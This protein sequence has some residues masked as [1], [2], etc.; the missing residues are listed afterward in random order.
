MVNNIRDRY[1]FK[2]KDDL[3]PSIF[4]YILAIVSL[5]PG[6]FIGPRI[7]LLWYAYIIILLIF[8]K[9][10]SIIKL[11]II[12]AFIFGGAYQ[13][14]LIGD[15]SRALIVRGINFLLYISIVLLYLKYPKNKNIL[16][17]KYFKYLY[18]LF[19]IIFLSGLINLIDPAN[20][21]QYLWSN[22][23]WVIFALVINTIPLTEKEHKSFVSLIIGII[24]VNSIFGFIQ[25]L[26]LPAQ[27]TPDGYTPDYADLASGML[28]VT[29]GPH[30]TS[31]CLAIG[32]YF[33]YR[34]LILGDKKSIF[35]IILLFLQP[36]ISESKAILVFSM[37]TI[38]L[39]LILITYYLKIFKLSINKIFYG[40]IILLIIYTGI[41]FYSISKQ[42]YYKGYSLESALEHYF[43]S[44]SSI[45]DFSKVQGY[46]DA[47]KN[48]APR[49]KFGIFFGI[50]PS[51]FSNQI[52]GKYY[53]W[54]YYLGY[55]ITERTRFTSADFRI[56]EMTQFISEVGIF[57]FFIFIITIYKL[58][59]LLIKN[60]KSSPDNG[61]KIFLIFVSQ[62]LIIIVFNSFYWVGL[63]S[64]LCYSY[65]L[66][67]FISYY[68]RDKIGF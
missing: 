57:G 34:F 39:S 46:I 13:Y 47:F 67:I 14:N 23:N 31:L 43:K 15:N 3:I 68:F 27:T 12:W 22:F 6:Y 55:D 50:G 16:L 48:I 63:L 60:A 21:L 17:S 19:F 9:L 29:E 25:Q 56:T 41:E 53:S 62:L 30:L 18:I 4:I 65:P 11:S 66:W 33:V 52:R 20:F 45:T 7:L 10:K 36:F 2:F 58:Y 28:G 8:N 37:F 26:F 38:V 44:K 35:L 32:S 5:I 1:K 61:E 40:I 59:M 51:N 54:L 42:S 49:G 64:T 24:I